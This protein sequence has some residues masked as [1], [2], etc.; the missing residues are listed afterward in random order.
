MRIFDRFT[1]WLTGLDSARRIRLAG[2]VALAVVAAV[3]LPLWAQQETWATLVSGRGYDA[4]LSAAA[5]V[6]GAGITYRITG[7]DTLEVP[8]TRLG[9]ARAAVGASSDLPGLADVSKLQL[10]LTPQ[11]QEWAFLR[12]AEGDLARMINGIDGIV[13]S[14]VHV[15]PRGQSLYIGEERPASASVFVKLAPG[16]HLGTG[17]VRAIVNLVASAVDGLDPE[18]VS[19]ADDTGTLLAGGDADEG[20]Q[21][22]QMRSLVEY[23]RALEVSYER[24]V[25]QALLPVLGYG[26]GF[27]VTSTVDLDLTSRETTT[28]KVDAE[29]QA[30]VS[31]VNEETNDTRSRPGGAPGVDSNMPEKAPAGQGVGS[32]STRT[33]NTV[34]YTYPTVD[35]I[36]HMP[37]GG[38]RRVSVAV[39]VDAGRIAALVEKSAGKLDAPT[40]QKQIDSAVRAAVGFDADRK[41]QLEVSYLPFA[42]AQWNVEGPADETPVEIGVRL[43]PYGLGSPHWSH[44]SGSWF[45]PSLP[46]S[47]PR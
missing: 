8:A 27:S 6:E 30:V 22:H 11:A 2:A 25:A 18:H 17:Q 10:G 42:E 41:D 12:S 43:L 37:Q 44:S 34:N 40:L 23:R 36:A 26:G 14:Q 16:G 15:V 47:S 13:G 32:E 20:D 4:A 3:A 7:T 24:S 46:R 21:G 9:A 35:E 19:V 5:S 28:R 38:V 29:R 31:E 1:A 45:A 39:Q 33:A